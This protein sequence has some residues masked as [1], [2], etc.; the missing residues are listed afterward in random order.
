MGEERCYTRGCF[1]HRAVVHMEI[2]RD[3]ITL[4]ACLL[5]TVFILDEDDLLPFGKKSAFML[6]LFWRD[7]AM[8]ASAFCII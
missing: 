7:A 8:T 1:F 6:I 2:N 3:P 5:L 4:R